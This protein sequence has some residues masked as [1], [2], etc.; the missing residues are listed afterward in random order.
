M[1][2]VL[3]VRSFG[4]KG[5][6]I[7]DDSKAIANALAAA[8]SVGSTVFFPAG[9]YMI[10]FR[11]MSALSIPSKVVLQG[12][13]RHSTELVF[14]PHDSSF[15]NVLG[16]VGQGVRFVNLTM[17]INWP[18]PGKDIVFMTMNSFLTI[19]NCIFNGGMTD[20]GTTMSYNAYCI[21]TPS[22]GTTTDIVLRDS[23]ITRFLYPFLKPNTCTSSESRIRIL[24]N[25]FV[26]NYGEDCSFNSPNGGCRDVLV[27]GN[28]FREKKPF[29][30]KLYCAFAS[31]SNV[32]IMN[33]QFSG[34]CNDAIHLEENCQNVSVIGNV[35]NI[36]GN[37]V[38]MVMEKI[39]SAAQYY[40][41]QNVVVSNNVITRVSSSANASREPSS[42]NASR[43]K[44]GIL[45][46]WNGVMLEPA[47]RCVISG[48]VISGFASGISSAASTTSAVQVS[49]NVCH[50]CSTGFF[51]QRGCDL[52]H[53]N[54]SSFCDIGVRTADKGGVLK[55]H[56]FIEC[57]S[58][59]V[60]FQGN[61]LLI[62][63]IFQ[64]DIASGTGGLRQF[65]AK[66]THIQARLTAHCPDFT[67]IED[68]TA[69]PGTL[70]RV[71]VFATGS[72]SA[73]GLDT[74]IDSAGWISLQMNSG[75]AG[76]QK[77][78]SHWSGS[79]IVMP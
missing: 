7:T 20:T 44:T 24:N 47:R 32:Q 46:V 22:I 25:D 77:A 35:M 18:T 41:P 71:P 27:Q 36:D 62:D 40:M 79:V 48:N 74:V 1:T 61:L 16:T 55:S 8:S 9:T 17:K 15:R 12:E 29:G 63:P 26:S 38:F 28:I 58:P 10:P 31:V 76:K 2:S 45:L 64:A 57:K 68:I 70:K 43:D 49:S 13:S 56:S 54:K 19:E 21:N 52:M 11:G 60:A 65:A 59:A 51:I 75:N 33:N 14:V 66:N 39:N 67:R 34:A 72:A 4:A 53:S 37:G 42:A 6:G 50:D 5:D 30:S 69:S 23:T 3:S 73:A 78:I